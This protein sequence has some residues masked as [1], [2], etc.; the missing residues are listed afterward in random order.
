MLN[1]QIREVHGVAKG[2]NEKDESLLRWFGHIERMGND[3]IAKKSVVGCPRMRWIDTVNECLK[4]SGGGLDFRSAWRLVYDR[5][6]SQVCEGGMFGTY[7]R[8]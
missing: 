7:S 8:G 2:V 4:K 6:D 5:S 1:P 3:R